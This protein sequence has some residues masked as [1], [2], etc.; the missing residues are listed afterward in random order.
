MRDTELFGHLLELQDPWKVAR[1]KPSAATGGVDVWVKHAARTQFACPHCG[2]PLS[3]YD[4]SAEQTWR[5]SNPVSV[6]LFLHARPPQVA[7]P[8]H[9]VCQVRLPWAEPHS[10]FSPAI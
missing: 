8:E 7:C 5:H 1:V 2:A 10:G 4:H 9:G 3:V 6:P